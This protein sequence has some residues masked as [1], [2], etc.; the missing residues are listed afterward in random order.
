MLSA[1]SKPRPRQNCYYVQYLTKCIGSAFI[2][3]WAKKVQGLVLVDTLRQSLTSDCAETKQLVIY[4]FPCIWGFS[5]HYYPHSPLAP[6]QALPACLERPARAKPQEK[7][8]YVS[9]EN[10]F[11]CFS[12]RSTW[13]H[14]RKSPNDNAVPNIAQFYISAELHS[15]QLQCPNVHLKASQ[16]S[17]Q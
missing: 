15:R 2:K 3:Y 17:L 10:C 7:S 12:S 14:D 4:L 13:C 16:G 8:T 1:T 11:P 5:V 6:V 9:D